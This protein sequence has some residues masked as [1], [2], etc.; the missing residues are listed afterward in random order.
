MGSQTFNF[1]CRVDGSPGCRCICGL[2]L[3]SIYGLYR[4]R[5]LVPVSPFTVIVEK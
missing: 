1:V 5:S 2:F 4:E 3:E